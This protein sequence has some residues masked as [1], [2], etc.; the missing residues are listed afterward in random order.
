MNLRICFDEDCEGEEGIVGKG[1]FEAVAAIFE[2][3]CFAEAKSGEGERR[4][5]KC[6]P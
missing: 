2:F 4:G 3:V 1:G 5:V 6:R